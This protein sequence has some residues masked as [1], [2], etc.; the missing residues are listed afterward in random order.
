MV[1]PVCGRDGAEVQGRLLDVLLKRPITASD[2][3]RSFFLLPI[4][5]PPLSL[6]LFPPPSLLVLTWL[7]PNRQPSG[8]VSI[9]SNQDEP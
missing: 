1:E 8:F 6:S 4:P 2:T 3:F 9:R 5:P 7:Y